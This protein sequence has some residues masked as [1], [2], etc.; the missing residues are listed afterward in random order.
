MWSHTETALLVLLIV[1]TMLGEPRGPYR[2]VALSFRLQQASSRAVFGTAAHI[3][4][5]PPSRV[6]QLQVLL[7]QEL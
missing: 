6:T 7:D 5:M 4:T 3:C 1:L 2:G